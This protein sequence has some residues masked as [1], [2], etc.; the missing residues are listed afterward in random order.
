MGGTRLNDARCGAEASFVARANLRKIGIVPPSREYP[1]VIRS[2]RASGRAAVLCRC[3]G[4]GLGARSGSPCRLD[5]AGWRRWCRRPG[6][7][8]APD[9][10]A[11]L[12]AKLLPAVVN[13][14]TTQTIKPDSGHG[15]PGP[16]HA[17]TSRPARRS[18]NSSRIS[19]TATKARP[20]AGQP[21]ALPRRATSLGSGFI[22]DPSG[23]VVTNNHVIADADE[24]TVTLAGQHQ[25]QGRG[26]RARH[27]GRSRAAADQAGEAAGRRSSS[28]T[29]TRPASATGCWRSATRSASAAR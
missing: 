4:R 26:G 8:P 23:L 10:F 24:I 15:G 21:Q 14:S 18:R 5:A 20:A 19:S 27:Q 2:H 28:A 1:S 29:A 17:A 7:K 11:D 16:D 6:R 13:I 12:A 22:I 9:S 25:L 3:A